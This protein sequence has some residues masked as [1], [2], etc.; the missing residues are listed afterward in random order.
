MPLLF[1]KKHSSKNLHGY[2]TAGSFGASPN[3]RIS[4]GTGLAS[5]AAPSSS[6]HLPRA[7][8]TS[9]SRRTLPSVN[10]LSS[11]GNVARQTRQKTRSSV[12]RLR[13]QSLKLT[14][15]AKNPKLLGPVVKKYY[16]KWHLKHLIPLIFVMAYMLLGAVIFYWL[17]GFA[18]QKRMHNRTQEYRREKNLFVKRIEEITQDRAAS[19]TQQR[20][21]FVEEALDH[22]HQQ[23][24]VHILEK[25]P[26]WTLTSAICG[27]LNCWG[28][29]L[30]VIYAI[31]GIPLMLITL[32]ELG[33][34]LYKTINELVA[35]F[36]NNAC[37]FLCRSTS[38]T[39]SHMLQERK[40][41]FK[42]QTEEELTLNLDASDDP[43]VKAPSPTPSVEP[44]FP[45]SAIKSPQFCKSIDTDI[46]S[47]KDFSP[48]H[49]EN[50]YDDDLELLDKQEEQEPVTPPRMPV[51]VALSCTL[52]WI[53]LCAALFKIWKQTGLM[54]RVAISCSS[55]CLQLVWGCEC[56]EEGFDGGVLCLLSLAFH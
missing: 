48:E 19:V 4:S 28:R 13:L 45:V 9:S 43:D 1:T 27:L 35:E 39:T 32:N 38:P 56:K 26:Q 14:E 52:G 30:T 31:V 2:N 25:E 36:P 34:F 55:A 40:V 21:K 51:L 10:T 22:F 50:G 37:G 29:I 47:A 6:S 44:R 5:G 41:S 46:E 24:R 33:K 3:T 15:Y 53:F 49:Q 12:G 16:Q 17:E 7:Q 11:L 18:E 23:L 54:Q 8:S 42:L 20:R